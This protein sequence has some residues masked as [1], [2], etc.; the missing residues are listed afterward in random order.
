MSVA[1]HQ[2][3]EIHLELFGGRAAVVVEHGDRIAARAALQRAAA[4]LRQWHARLT[5][6]EAGSELSRL[7]RDPRATVPASPILLA[8]AQAVSW[9]GALS[10]GLVDATQLGALERAGYD[11]SL[12]DIADPAPTG[13]GAPSGIP[14]DARPDPRCAWERVRADRVTGVVHRPP[15]LR[16]DSG[17]LAKGLAADDVAALLGEVDRVAV[18]CA[19]DLRLGGRLPTAR[20]VLVADPLGDGHVAELTLPASSAVATSGVTRRRWRRRGELGDDDFAHHLLDPATGRPAWTGVL[21]ATALAPSAVEAE[22]RAK[23]ALLSGPEHAPG[24]LPHGG[25]LV[26]EGGRVLEVSS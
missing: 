10:G 23:A 19:G 20:P 18:D 6:F 1:T 2:R 21:Q 16:L 9:A 3:Q 13:P 4:R 25:V 24:F 15:G 12:R 17:G 8:L 22:V 26:L 7:N 11:R 5:R 14:R